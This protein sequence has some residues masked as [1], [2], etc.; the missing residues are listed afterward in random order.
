[1]MQLSSHFYA[2]VD[3]AGG[4]EPFALAKI[5]LD[6]GVR[7]M[8]LRLKESSS[9]DFLAVARAIAGLCRVHQAM[10]MI[11]DRAD[12]AQ[13]ADAAGVHVGQE[14]LPLPA[15]RRIVG[16]GKIV[17]VSTH[18]VEQARAAAQ[19]GA[20]YIG[21]GAIYAGGVKNVR[22]AQGL[23]R[24]Q[25][26]RAAVKLPIVAIG[27]IT[28]ATVRDVLRA[29]ANAAAIISDVVFA[30]DISAKVRSILAAQI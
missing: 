3:A 7:I 9:R 1:M 6:A 26:V 2:M 13:L 20:D 27:G 15:A 18:N 23:E 10:L 14:D 4:H 8:Q 30:P 17:G 28:E 12:I 5:L 25:Q 16:P 11:N 24:L 22:N 19:E 29:G 21:V